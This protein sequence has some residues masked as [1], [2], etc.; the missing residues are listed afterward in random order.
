MS[1]LAAWIIDPALIPVWER[2]RV[3]FEQTG[4]VPQGSV[5]LLLTS[6]AQRQSVGALLG[7]TVTSDRVR[8]DLAVLDARL[9]DRSGAGGLEAVLTRLAGRAPEDRPALRAAQDDARDRPLALAAELVKAA[10]ARD[11]IAGLRRT[12]LLTNR[13]AAEDVVRASAAVLNELTDPDG[14][15]RTQSRV[16]LG[17]RLLGDSHALDGDRLVHQVVLRGLAAASD[18]PVPTGSRE[19]EQ[20]WAAYGVEP[21]LLSRTC[22]MWGLRI[23]GSHSVAQRLRL[24]ADSGDPVHLTE[25]D[26]RRAGSF[27][28]VPDTRVL[29]CENPR[30]VEAIA[31][32]GLSEWPTVCTSGVPNLVVDRVLTE[33]SAAGATLLYHGD[34]DW[35]G[36]AIANRVSAKH[37]VRPWQMTAENYV[38]AVT[39]GAPELVG[40]PVEPCWDAELGAA[41]RTYGRVVHEESVLVKLLDAL[42]DSTNG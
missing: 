1:D 42:V 4:L 18:L 15:R 17:A 2:I 36:I 33:L 21:D 8:I 14:L 5:T 22:L 30:V 20:L 13:A 31:E 16:E 37:A 38:E 27:R 41:M 26:L 23:E 11:W 24:A 35:P 40:R 6:R 32:A 28:P 39:P 34:F 29:V 7:R 19:R 3:R 10:W 25:W 12:G 9:R